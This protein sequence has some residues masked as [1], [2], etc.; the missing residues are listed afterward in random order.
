MLIC[1]AFLFPSSGIAGDFIIDVSTSAVFK[2]GEDTMWRCYANITIQNINSENITPIW[3]C[4]NL[5]NI[6]FVNETSQQLTKLAGYDF[7]CD[8]PLMLRPQDEFTLDLVARAL[9]FQWI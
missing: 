2:R 8:P 4:I 6:T 5:V 1:L 3:V 9:L 7:T